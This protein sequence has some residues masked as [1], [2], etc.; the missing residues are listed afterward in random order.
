MSSAGWGVIPRSV[1][2]VAL[3]L[4]GVGCMPQQPP[5]PEAVDG[6][7]VIAAFLETVQR[8][9]LTF[10][11]I[12]EGVVELEAVDSNEEQ[13]VEISADLD[14]AGEDAVGEVTFDIGPEIT[15]D[16]LIVD[17]EA[18]TESPDGEWE[19]VPNVDPEAQAPLNPFTRLEPGDLEYVGPTDDDLHELRTDVWL[20]ADPETLEDQGW[21][22]VEFTDNST[23]IVVTADGTPVRM[24]FVGDA[25]GVYQGEDA[26]VHFD[27]DYE[28]SEVGEPVEIPEP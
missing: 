2:C 14:V 18:Y 23:E 5:P 17:D 1:A 28:F 21:D 8:D 15:V 26:V 16:V 24:H 25:T 7:A 6:D 20:G 22:D 19:P 10:H 12:T 27:V 9:D 3:L 13:T 11:S 4:A